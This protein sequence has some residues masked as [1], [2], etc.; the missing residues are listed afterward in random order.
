MMRLQ[1]NLLFRNITKFFLLNLTPIISFSIIFIFLFTS[2]FVYYIIPQNTN[3]SN[4]IEL[5]IAK[6]SPGFSVDYLYQKTNNYE[7]NF[8]KKLLYGENLEYKKIPIIYHQIN[9]DTIFFVE[10]SDSFEEKNIKKIG[11]KDLIVNNSKIIH[12]QKFILGTDKFGRDLLSRI[13][14]GSRLS[15]SVGFF[16]VLV[17]LCIG[18]FLGLIAGYFGGKIDFIIQW[19][20]NVVWSIQTLLLVISISLVL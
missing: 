2:I 5:S 14:L 13:I 6:K 11:L 8:F 3:M 20:I 10:Y 18:L 9:N 19:V 7:N 1:Y 4:E 12:S 15:L 16:S 17:S